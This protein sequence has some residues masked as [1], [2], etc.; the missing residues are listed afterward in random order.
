VLDL[1]AQYGLFL[2]KTLTWVVA[3][4]IV[5]SVIANVAQHMRGQSHDHLDVSSVNDRLREMGAVLN[6]ELLDRRAMKAEAKARKA[7]EKAQQRARKHGHSDERARV[8]LL[9]FH[10]DLRASQTAHLR[11]EISAVLQVARER[12]EVMLRL[13]SEGGMVHGYGLAASQLQR[14][15]DRRIKLTVAVDKV[16]ASGGYLMACVADRIIAAPFA[17]LGSIGVVAQLPNFNRLLKKNEIDFELHTA[18]QHKRTLTLFGENTEA[19]RTKFKEEIEDVY[20]LFKSFVT[21]NRPQ[22]QIEQV[23]TGEHWYGA[24]ALALKLVDEIK[25]SDDWLLERAKD[26]DIVEVHYRIRPRM[27]DRL[28]HGFAALRA[29]ARADWLKLR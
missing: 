7:E 28:T 9:D 1:L 17:I 20:A 24:R 21:D 3:I 4:V 18:G 8:F 12:D 22:L 14:I 16:A 6:A 19:A 26:S 2:A 5:V 25:T 29:A 27:L 13:E 10:G 11:E 15:R 23:A